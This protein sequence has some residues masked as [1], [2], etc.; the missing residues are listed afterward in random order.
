MTRIK[1]EAE[2]AIVYRMVI[3][4]VQ[5]FDAAFKQYHGR[6]SSLGSSLETYL[7]VAAVL[8]GEAENRLFTAHKLSSYLG[9]ARGT[10]Q[11]KLDHL[12]TV[13]AVERIGA[14]YRLGDVCAKEAGHV[15]GMTNVVV[16]AATKL[17]KLDTR[18]LG[19]RNETV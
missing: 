18:P 7:I 5:S 13:G 6:G 8:I 1:Q 14:K 16:T 11:R 12:E 2:R 3:E 10:V 17:S 9:L 15:D 19:G 4:I